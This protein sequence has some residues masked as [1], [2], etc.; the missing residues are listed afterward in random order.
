VAAE[1]S[2]MKARKHKFAYY[3]EADISQEI[4]IMVNEASGR[5]DPSRTKK[6][7]HFF[8]THTENRLK[9]LKRDVRIID[10]PTSFDNAIR[11]EDNSFRDAVIFKEMVD[12]IITYLPPHLCKPF[13]IMIED[14]G[15]SVS[16]YMKNKVRMAVE[17][18]LEKY[19]E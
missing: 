14:D 4:W 13:R 12:F 18:L 3:E 16:Q 1:L 19:H 8:N 6:P 11:K 17:E 2:R 10:W 5:F 15:N 7:L 9:N